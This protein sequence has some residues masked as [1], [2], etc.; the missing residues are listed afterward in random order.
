MHR[1]KIS[2]KLVL[3]VYLSIFC[4]KKNNALMCFVAVKLLQ[5]SDNKPFPV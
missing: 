2:F 5:W 3:H 4:T 1:K